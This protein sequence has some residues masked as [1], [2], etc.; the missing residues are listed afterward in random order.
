[1]G[2]LAALM[3]VLCLGMAATDVRAAECITNDAWT[4]AD[5]AAHVGIG[6]LS[7][8]MVTAATGNAWAGFAAGVAVGLA[9]EAYDKRHPDAHTCSAQDFLATAGG[10]AIGASGT[11]WIIRRGF[12]G[13]TWEF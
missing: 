12:I 4:G 7:A 6:A 13:R 10:A 8:S 3:W 11:R 9:K 2:L 5:K 1:M